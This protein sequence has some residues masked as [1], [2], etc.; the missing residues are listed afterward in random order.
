M[1]KMLLSILILLVLAVAACTVQQTGVVEDT[2]DDSSD[3]SDT[4]SDTKVTVSKADDKTGF[5]GAIKIGVIYSLTGDAAAY[6][7]PVQRAT[8]IAIDEINAKGGI[9]GKKLEAIYEDGKCNPID[10]N[11]AAQKLVN[12]DK[13][14]VIIGGICSGE[15]L[16]AAPITEKAKVI[17]FSP[18]STSPDVTNAGDFVFRTAPSDA[19]AGVVASEYSYNELGAKKAAIVSESTDYSQGLRRVFSENFKKLGG[20]I[21][22]NEVYNTEDTDFRSQVTKVKAA[23]PDLIYLAPQTDAKGLLLMR[24]IKD[25][26]LNQQIV[27]S[28]TLI[29]RNTVDENAEL[30]EGLIGVEQKFD[31]KGLKASKMLA[32]YTRQANEEA[33]FPGFM[34]GAYDIVYL[35]YDA[36]REVGNDGEAIRDYLYGVKDYNGAV[37]KISFDENGDVLLDFSVKQAKDGVMVTLR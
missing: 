20:E 1:K 15:T 19:F 4:T 33:P 11:T 16:G 18:T 32:E 23:K 27:S 31:E 34:S 13:V 35:L 2:R 21:V 6:G 22:A 10:S 14:K 25:A 30:L 3:A 28:E 36:M 5:D 7:I 29:G 24:Q 37:G 12:I 9:D 8:K 17:L 26:G